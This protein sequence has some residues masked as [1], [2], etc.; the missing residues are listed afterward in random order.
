M[1]EGIGPLIFVEKGELMAEQL[2]KLIATWM[3]VLRL[4]ELVY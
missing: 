2:G 1:A 3:R 4:G